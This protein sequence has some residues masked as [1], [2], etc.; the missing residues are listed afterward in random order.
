[1]NTVTLYEIYPKRAIQEGT[2]DLVMMDRCSNKKK[3]VKSARAWGGVV[4]QIA[5]EILT[6]YPLTRR[7]ISEKI[8]F[9]HRP[10]R[11]RG[12]DRERVTRKHVMG[13]IKKNYRNF[14]G[15]N[16]PARAGHPLKK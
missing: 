4:V 7:V 8:I 12:A 13:K 9:I 5:A 11:K 2:R 1:M 16:K 6:T 15:I 10:A 3:A 14:R